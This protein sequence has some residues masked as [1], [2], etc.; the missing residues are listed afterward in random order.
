MSLVS[1]RITLLEESQTIKMAK[2]GRALT[3]KGI[4][5]INLSVGEPDFETPDHIK[6]AAKIAIDEGY[7]HYSPV[8][9]YP[10]LRKSVVDKLKR[11]NNLIFEPNQIVISTG[12]KQSLSNALLCLLNPGDEVIIPTPYWVSY[13]EMVKMAEGKSVF[14]PTDDLSNFKISPNQLENAI[15]S[16]TKVFL[17]SSPNNPTGA[18]Y[19]QKELAA[20]VEV[21][22]RYTQI[23][24]ISDEIYE[25]INYVGSHNSIAS[26]PSLKERVILINGVS[27][28]FAMTGWRLGYMASS[29]EIAQACEKLQSQVTSGTCS[30]AQRAAIT[31]LDASLEPTLEMCKA[32]LRRRNRMFE[33][34]KKIPGIEVNLPEGAFYFFPKIKSFFGK[35][36][37]D[38]FIENSADLALYILNEAHVATVQGDAF[39]SPDHLR[40]SYAASDKDLEIALDRMEMALGKLI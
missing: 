39:G 17:F 36:Y 12:A 24:I 16:K 5:I 19:S 26:F 30:I 13:S 6:E 35:H 4:H 20:L 11:E 14:I 9:G 15:N 34:L 33:R 37:R 1:N 28:A 22:D 3:S 32:F 25:H 18:V 27:K 7:S 29:L 2:M 10:E 23:Q 40:I 38:Q 21:F 31:A 8:A